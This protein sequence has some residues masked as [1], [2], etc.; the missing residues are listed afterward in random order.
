MEPI[1]TRIKRWGN[2]FAVVVPV[3][4]IKEEK[5]ED[6]AEVTVTIHPR[7]KTKVRDV[8]GMLKGTFKRSTKELMR[9]VDEAFEPEAA[10]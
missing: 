3:Q 6:G 8:F 1:Q 2:S 5:L 10:G 9:E 4:Y 7:G